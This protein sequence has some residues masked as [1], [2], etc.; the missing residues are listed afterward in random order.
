[1]KKLFYIIITII[2]IAIVLIFMENFASKE[3]VSIADNKDNLLILDEKYNKEIRLSYESES[4]YT[5]TNDYIYLTVT[6]SYAES[7][8]SKVIQIN[9]KTGD[10]KNIFNSKHEQAA[11]QSLYSDGKWV[12]WVDDYISG[13]L[14]EIYAMNEDTGKIIKL[15]S[16]SESIHKG[17]PKIAEDVI[18]WTEF[19]MKTEISKIQLYNTKNGRIETISERNDVTYMN[20]EVSIREG[21]ILFSD[22]VEN[23]SVLKLYNIENKK[24][25]TYKLDTKYMGNAEFIDDEKIMYIQ[26]QDLEFTVNN[27]IMMY[28]L[29]TQKESLLLPSEN[30][31]EYYYRRALMEDNILLI[32]KEWEYKIYELIGNEIKEKP[33]INFNDSYPD[34]VQI[35]TLNKNYF[36]V[37]GEKDG[38]YITLTVTDQL[39]SLK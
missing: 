35:D 9:R 19:D 3:N 14:A 10:Y 28:D 27:Q 37:G 34:F 2:L 11:T 31:L 22:K 29:V 17:D 8:G 26:Y 1:M 5:A 13:G 36:I 18:V 6:D 21:Q 4:S 12:S 25:I 7:I 23:K 38:E 16:K 33:T 24:I 30:N 15:G 39:K 20:E 32:Q